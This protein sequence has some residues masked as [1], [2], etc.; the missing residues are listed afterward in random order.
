[1][2]LPPLPVDLKA[3]YPGFNPNEISRICYVRFGRA[4]ARQ[5]VKHVLVE[6]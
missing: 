3:E 4:P 6:D 5:K 1:M 2:S